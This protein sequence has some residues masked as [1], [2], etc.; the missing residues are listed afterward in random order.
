[1]RIILHKLFGTNGQKIVVFCLILATALVMGCSKEIPP[2]AQAKNAV[3]ATVKTVDLN[4]A[5]RE[6]L[7]TIPYVGAVM[8]D[9]IITFREANGGFENPE[10]LMLIQGMSDKRFRSIRHLIRADISK[11]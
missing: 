11:K 9:R 5:D 1:M 4:S 6:E 2:S 7:Q 8:A 3:P 10:Q